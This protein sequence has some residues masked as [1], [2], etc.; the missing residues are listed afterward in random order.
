MCIQNN[1]YLPLAPS[2]KGSCDFAS[3]MCLSQLLA[4]TSRVASVLA[5]EGPLYS[6]ASD[7]MRTGEV[8][9]A[10]AEGAA[11]WCTGS[12]SL[13]LPGSKRAFIGE[14]AKAQADCGMSS[15]EGGSECLSDCRHFPSFYKTAM[16]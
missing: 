15:W 16:I 8:S 6:L 12:S 14:R 13:G 9:E 7:R 4:C 11:V 2:P 10:A 1:G 3:Q 5:I